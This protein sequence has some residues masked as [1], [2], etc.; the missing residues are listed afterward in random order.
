MRADVRLYGRKGL[1]RLASLSHAQPWLRAV[2][3][4]VGIRPVLNTWRAAGSSE[5]PAVVVLGEESEELVE[6]V[7]GDLLQ[8]VAVWVVTVQEPQ[9]AGDE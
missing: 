1:P 8:E 3:V 6:V 9:G 7:F 4:T 5:R 2:S